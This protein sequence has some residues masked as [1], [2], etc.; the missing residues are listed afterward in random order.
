MKR[1]FLPDRVQLVHDASGVEAI[2]ARFSA[3]AY[4]LHRHD[5]WLVG[6]T[7]QGVQDFL[8]R[9]ARRRSTPGCVILIEPQEAHDGQAGAAGGFVYRML[10]LPRPWL[11]AGLAD[12]PGGEPGFI[13]SLCD[14]PPLG[15][16]I[17]AACRVLSRSGERLARDAALDGVL[18]RLRPHLGRKPRRL[19]P[20]RD[21]RVARRA[22]ERLHD[23][24][25]G[26]PGADA[27]A[28]A[29]GAADR[30][31]LARAFR[32]AYG[33]SPHAYL[34]QIRLLRARHLLSCGLAP[35]DVAAACGF[36]DQSHLGRRFRRAYGVTPAAYRALCTDVPDRRRAI[37]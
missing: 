32:A 37:A 8:C 5:D 4:D 18:D 34:V 9:G 7:D 24:L 10:Y 19:P 12:A 22:R 21:D 6:V 33:T 31:Q 30:F 14:D 35:A 1:L 20:G 17:R 28:R 11:A 25:A 2:H 27:L 3:H 29:A 13:A 26:D 15:Q 16:A 23:D 36:A